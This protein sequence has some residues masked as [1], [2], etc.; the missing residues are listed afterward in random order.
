[1]FFKLYVG[2]TNIFPFAA[3]NFRLEFPCNKVYFRSILVLIIYKLSSHLY[4]NVQI[5]ETI[6]RFEKLLFILHN[7][8]LIIW[9]NRFT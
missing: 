9:G 5:L 8:A 2:D 1:M 4:S 3:T 7:N 6:L